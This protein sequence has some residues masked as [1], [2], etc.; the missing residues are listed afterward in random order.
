MNKEGGFT[1]IE[2]IVVIAILGIIGAVLVPRFNDMAIRARLRAD[3]DSVKV[4]QKQIE[5]YYTE[6]KEMPGNTPASIM[7]TLVKEDYINTRYLM[8]S[9]I[10]LETYGTT[11]VFDTASSQLKLKVTQP[12]YDLFNHEEDKK[13]WIS[14]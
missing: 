13:V 9:S 14:K 7:S 5:I 3:V 2:L 11:I 1:L 4:L 8:G 10:K 6:R 12:Q